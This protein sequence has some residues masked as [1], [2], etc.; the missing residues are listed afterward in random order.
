MEE[1]VQYYNC[2]AG[3]QEAVA[4][5]LLAEWSA[6]TPSFFYWDRNQPK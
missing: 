3:V 4:L 6:I 5:I 2:R 1:T